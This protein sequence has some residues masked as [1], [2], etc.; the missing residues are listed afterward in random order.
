MGR[1]HRQG[2]ATL[3]GHTTMSALS[4]AFS[5]DGKTLAS[6]SMTTRSSSGKWPPARNGPPLRGIPGCLF[7]GLQSGWQDPGFGSG[8][9]TVKLWEVATGKEQATLQGHTEWS[10]PWRSVPDGKTLASG[11][12]DKTIKLWDVATG[13][14][15]A[16]LQ[17]HTDGSSPW[18]SV[19]MARP[20][21]RGAGQDHQALGRGH[22][23]MATMI[24]NGVERSVMK[25]DNDDWQLHGWLGLAV[26]SISQQPS[27]LL[28]AETEG[29]SHP[30]RAYRIGS[31][32][33]F[34][35][36]WQDPGLGQLGQDHQALGR[37]YRQR[38]SHPS[39][40]NRI[41]TLSIPWP[42][43]PMAG[44]WPRE[45]VTKPSNSGTWLPARNGPLSR[46]IRTCHVRG[47]Q[48][49]W[50][51]P[52]VGSRDKTIKLWEVA[53]GKERTTLQGA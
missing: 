11:S 32:R 1:G 33:G 28:K 24:P 41:P 21:P 53:T 34:Q 42:S 7:R 50:Q 20:W 4:V 46:D 39:R 12:M 47:L 5:P 14:E 22:R 27:S 2:G 16:T 13:K 17:G 25:P 30:S 48:S 40:G 43:V 51:D 3:Q 49:G 37:D 38:A 9:K 52:G 19:P 8:D 29:T 6:G 26:I 10:S 18:H 35:S 36:R 44:P 45:A 23:Q 15:R 31:L